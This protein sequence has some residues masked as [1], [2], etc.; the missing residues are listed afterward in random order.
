[1]GSEIHWDSSPKYYLMKTLCLQRIRKKNGREVDENDGRI[2]KTRRAMNIIETIKVYKN[3][4]LTGRES[5]EHFGRSG[6]NVVA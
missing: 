2:V 6:E 1:M 3:L 4:E 5:G